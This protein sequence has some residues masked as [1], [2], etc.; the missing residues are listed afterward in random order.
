MGPPGENGQEGPK[1]TKAAAEFK[2]FLLNARVYSRA[3]VMFLR[4]NVDKRNESD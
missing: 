2:K 1:V 3:T 4:G